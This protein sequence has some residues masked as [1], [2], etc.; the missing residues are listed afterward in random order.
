MTN[1]DAQE[2][3][4]VMEVSQVELR[5]QIIRVEGRMD[6]LEAK[7]EGI[8]KRMDLLDKRMDQFDKRMDRFEARMDCLEAKMDRLL[9]F[10][11]GVTVVNVGAMAAGFWAVLAALAN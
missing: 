1:G 3:V 7:M 2:R 5:E 4:V 11:V 6:V 10:I 9:Y 8:D